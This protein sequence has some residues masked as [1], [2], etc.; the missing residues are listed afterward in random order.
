MTALKN[1][2][3]TQ[4][5]SGT[6][7][8]HRNQL[9]LPLSIL[10]VC[11]FTP[12]FIY[13]LASGNYGL[14]A[15]ILGLTLIFLINAF[16]IHRNEKPLIP[17]EILLFP[18]AL[19]IV[20]S[21]IYQGVYGTYW[22]YPLLLFYFF[23][24]S[25]K[26]ANVCSILLLFVT[27]FITWKYIE[28]PLTIRFAVS[29]SLLL[30]M[31]NIIVGVIDNLYDRLHQE[32]IRDPL[33]GSFNRR[34]MES[35]LGDAVAQKQR[36]LILPSLLALDIDFFKPIN[37]ELGHAT[38]DK[39]LKSLVKLIKQD[40]RQSDK[41][42]R[43]GGEEFLLFLPETNEEKAAFVAEKLRRKVANEPLLNDRTITVSIGVSEL[44]TGE[45]LDD[46]LKSADDAMYKAKE[47]GRNRV[48]RRNFT[49]QKTF[50]GKLKTERS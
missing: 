34:Y 15:A 35:R 28:T 49:D 17:F 9:L 8:A 20:L 23:V 41:L 16:S 48:V 2:N 40:I 36:E 30:V 29:L 4:I 1:E 24:L 38:G 43:V 25:R 12:F 19:A 47:T 22:C 14:G 39:V 27:T 32:S 33:T 31:A 13:N 21:T 46:W 18:A 10:G 6:T 11:C 26:M 44:Q 37:D 45:T 7:S 50:T 3:S 42:F 5:E